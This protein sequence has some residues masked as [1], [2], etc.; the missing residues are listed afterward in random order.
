MGSVQVV[1]GMEVRLIE[2]DAKWG[3]GSV[4]RAKQRRGRI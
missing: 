1:M 3:W 2:R 4:E